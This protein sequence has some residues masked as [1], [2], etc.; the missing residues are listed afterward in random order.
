MGLNMAQL[1]H[2]LYGQTTATSSV[3][4]ILDWLEPILILSS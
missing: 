2:G 4:T 1:H 3:I